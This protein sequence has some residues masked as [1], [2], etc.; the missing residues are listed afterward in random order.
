MFT[1]LGAVLKKVDFLKGQRGEEY[2]CN[3]PLQKDV[4]A[5]SRKVINRRTYTEGLSVKPEELLR[6]PDDKQE[7]LEQTSEVKP[8]GLEQTSE[9]KP[10]VLEQTPEVKPEGLEQTSRVDPN[11]KIKQGKRKCCRITFCRAEIVYTKR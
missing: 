10:E 6:N 2:Y 5:F 9:V 3:V 8:E 4:L 7:V 11:Q 1:D